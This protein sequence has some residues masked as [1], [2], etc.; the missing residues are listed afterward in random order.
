[1]YTQKKTLSEG[2]EALKDKQ[3]VDGRLF[4]WGQSLRHE[5]NLGAH[6]SGV[7]ATREDARDLIDFAIAICEYVFVLSARYDAYLKRRGTKENG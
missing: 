2:L 6:A 5:R 3:I 1:M 4:E 7:A